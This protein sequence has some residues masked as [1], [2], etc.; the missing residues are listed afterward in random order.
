MYSTGNFYRIFTQSLVSLK[1][2]YLIL[3]V[4]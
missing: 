4:S 2:K 1:L 3:L